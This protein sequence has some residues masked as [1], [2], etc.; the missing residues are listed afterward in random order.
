MLNPWNRVL[1]MPNCLA[2]KLT[3]RGVRVNYELGRAY[4]RPRSGAAP[5]SAHLCAAD[6]L[7]IVELHPGSECGP[8]NPDWEIESLL[9]LR[10]CCC[11]TCTE[12][13]PLLLAI[14]VRANPVL[15]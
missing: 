2:S 5:G 3:C 11:P 4:M 8:Q 6:A 12:M 1:Q 14:H 15:P 9:G 7:A 13:T 10:R